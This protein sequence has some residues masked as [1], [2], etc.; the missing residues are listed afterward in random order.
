M[1]A[2]RTAV[3]GFTLA[4]LLVAESSSLLLG[5]EEAHRLSLE[6]AKA[7]GLRN[8]RYLTTTPPRTDPDQP[9]KPDL[10]TFQ[11]EIRPL[12][13]QACTQCHGAEK[14][15]ADFR[16]DTLDPDL[17][18]GEDISWWLEVFDVISSGEMPPPDE[19][20]IE[21]A[22]ENRSR[23]VDW[24]TNEIQVASQVRRFEEG[25]TSFR[26]LTKYE[27]NYALQD[28]LGLPFDF[29]SD[30]PPEASSEDGFKNSSEMLQM[31]S[32]QFEDYHQI[33]R[34]A[35]R[36]AVVKGPKPTVS[37]FH[38]DLA[39][40]AEKAH[41]DNSSKNQEK[42]DDKKKK[43]SSRSSSAH[44]FDREADQVIASYRS[45]FRGR[46]YPSHESPPEPPKPGSN[47]GF[48]L[49]GGQKPSF[50]LGLALPEKGGLR[51][52]I[53]A[54]NASDDGEIPS[55]RLRF[56]YQPSNNSRT[57]FVVSHQDIVVEA[58]PGKEQY[59]EFRIPLSE[60]DRNPFR[61]KQIQKVNSTENILIEN[62][63]PSSKARI[64]IDSIEVSTP[65]YE[66]WPPSSHTR[67]LPPAESE[68]ELTYARRAIHNL[69]ALAWRREISEAEVD[70]KLALYETIRPTLE[71]PQDA[72]IEV[73]ANV[74]AS[75]H[76]LY[77]VQN[78]E[79]DPHEVATRLS[80]F[81]WSSVPD[82]ELLELARTDQLAPETLRKQAA[83]LL[84]DP[85]AERFSKHFVR[86]WL[87]MDLLDYLEVDPKVYRNFTPALRSSMQEEP[88]VFFEELLKEDASIVNF[89]HADFAMVNRNLRQ[90]YRISD[91]SV[92]TG[93]FQ[94][95][96][97]EG[98]ERG[99]ILTQAGLLAMNSDGKD[100]H[101]LKRGIWVLEKIL[102]DPPP[103]PPPSVPE[104]DLADP[105]VAEM[106]LKE[107]MIDH[108][109]DAACM[110]CHQKID[111]WGIVFENYDALGSWR[112]EMGGVPVDASAKLF[113]GEELAGV[114]GLKRHLLLHRQDEF[115]SAMVH[116][117]STY[118]L[119]RPLT[120]ADHSELEAITRQLRQNGDG[121]NTLIEL[122]VTSEL[123]W[124]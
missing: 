5:E 3:S 63:N 58:E 54:S 12:L 97:I 71:D 91:D 38:I 31:S 117:L 49:P 85:R 86:Q 8:S 6:E 21:L 47:F 28:L 84:R 112:D 101:P 109:N 56:G 13:E 104:I 92:R 120:F 115:A 1:I 122:I 100:S 20:D 67:L 87:G 40:D 43:P 48:I 72:L 114:E 66:Q 121:L 42:K 22:D 36:K 73:M 105:R 90:H 16:L 103:P 78:P 10:A 57:N 4:L 124:N 24:L 93:E 68:D 83:R 2:F 23:I 123:F 53:R 62:T 33:A 106:T 119:G 9:P 75:P 30:L 15:K 25:H 52:R 35:L 74:L 7:I 94:R 29:A 18:T 46:P 99:G 76:F 59:Y 26:R 111:P 44:Y 95:V 110:S 96:A 89:L 39:A 116:K 27:Y 69:M 65:Y 82:S 102:N 64:F 80:I 81:L 17:A 50:N 34:E 32:S 60:I 113:N 107:R 55:L 11:K 37:Y 19:E 41:R 14:Q 79:P 98:V 61:G 51:V 70:R 118:A 45:N 108:R 77:L 88:I